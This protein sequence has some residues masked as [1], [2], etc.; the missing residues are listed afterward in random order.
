M[1]GCW[2]PQTC[3]SGPICYSSEQTSASAEASCTSPLQPREHNH[4]GA[5]PSLKGIPKAGWEPAGQE[6][7]GLRACPALAHMAQNVVYADLRFAKVMG[8]RSM[9]NQALE[10]GESP[11]ECPQ[12]PHHTQPHGLSHSPLPS[13]NSPWHGQSRDPL[14]E[15]AAGASGAGWGRGPAQPR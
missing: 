11:R 1:R 6:P 5:G 15:C 4:W 14:R 9:A 7:A 13:S 10:A 12:C 3:V 8:G 2:S